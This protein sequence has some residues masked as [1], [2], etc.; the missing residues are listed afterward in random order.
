VRF[1]YKY[2]EILLPDYS[3]AEKLLSLFTTPERA[4]TIAGD[5]AE[6]AGRRGSLWFWRQASGTAISLALRQVASAPIRMILLFLLG[7]LLIDAAIMLFGP[8]V[9]TVT[10]QPNPA[11]WQSAWV[12]WRLTAAFFTGLLLARLSAGREIAICGA[13]ALSRQLFLFS[14]WIW[15]T[16]REFPLAVPDGVVFSNL[17][18][19]LVLLL[20]GALHRFTAQSRSPD[21]GHSKPH[22]SP[23]R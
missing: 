7:N 20:A 4:V 21:S 14:T 22:R 9:E 1:A 10:V 23:S 5:F 15:I 3:V 16:T 17:W 19:A 13:V 8:F 6:D 2:L 18:P 12:I 11:I